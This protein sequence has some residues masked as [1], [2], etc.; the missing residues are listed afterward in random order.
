YV[1]LQGEAHDALA[2]TVSASAVLRTTLWSIALVALLGLAAGLTAF[3]LITRPLRALTQAVRNFD[4]DGTAAAALHRTDDSDGR[5][6]EIAVLRR[7]FAQMGQ[8]IA[9][10][11]RELTHQDQQ[12]R[13]LV[14]NI[15]HDLRTP[16]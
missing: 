14:A 1:V 8:R 5:G 10:Q 11:W 9:D 13:D 2:S 16:M 12:R 15:S 3:A 7:A 6:D 4:G